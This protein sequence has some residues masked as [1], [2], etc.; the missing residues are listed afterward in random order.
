VRA[1]RAALPRGRLIVAGSVTTREQIE[2]LGAAGVDAFTI[3]S[4]VFDGAFSPAKGALHSQLEDIL[5][6]CG[7]AG[8]LA[9]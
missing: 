8:R 2:A 5:A 1:A 9:A 3:G 7:R 6:A 4:A